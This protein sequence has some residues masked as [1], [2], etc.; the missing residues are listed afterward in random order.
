[1]FIT[2]QNAEKY[3]TTILI[4]NQ[5]PTKELYTHTV[6]PNCDPKYWSMRINAAEIF[7]SIFEEEELLNKKIMLLHVNYHNF[8][9]EPYYFP[10]EIEI[11]ELSLKNGISRTNHQIIGMSRVCSKGY[12]GRKLKYSKQ[13][14]M[15][16]CWHEHPDDH[17]QIS[18]LAKIFKRRKRP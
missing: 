2:L 15:I 3:T 18:S 13:P 6:V 5:I 8:F 16:N 12:G 1:M 17:V 4:L 10:A 9:G 14:H 7:E 11:V